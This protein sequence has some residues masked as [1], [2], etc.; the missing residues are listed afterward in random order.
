MWMMF[1]E[2]CITGDYS[3]G[4]EVDYYIDNPAPVDTHP[5]LT[6]WMALDPR[7]KQAEKL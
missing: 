7:R 4:Q 1:G 6:D 5:E 2:S 3:G